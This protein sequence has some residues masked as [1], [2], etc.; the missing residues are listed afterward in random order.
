MGIQDKELQKLSQEIS[1]KIS[2]FFSGN[3]FTLF[4]RYCKMNGIVYLDELSNFNF[5]V[6]LDESSFGVTKIKKIKERYKKIDSLC[7]K[8][9]GNKNKKVYE[10]TFYDF[11]LLTNISKTESD[12]E[13]SEPFNSFLISELGYSVRATNI[14]NEVKLTSIGKLLL[15]TTDKLLGKKNCGKTTIIEI[16][17]KCK[18]FLDKLDIENIETEIEKIIPVE[19]S[20]KEEFSI[21]NL[22]QLPIFSANAIESNKQDLHNS[23]FGNYKL[24]HIPFDVRTT[25]TMHRLKL[26]SL[27]ELLFFP[28]SSIKLVTGSGKKTIENIHKTLT[29]FY[30]VI[31][32]KNKQFESFQEMLTEILS[33][34]PE[35]LQIFFDRL[36][37]FDKD[38]TLESVGRKYNLTR[39][40]V[41]QIIEKIENLLLYPFIDM[42]LEEFY[43]GIDLVLDQYIGAVNAQMINV[44]LSE[45][46]DWKENVSPEMLLN[47]CLLNNRYRINKQNYLLFSKSENCNECNN[48]FEFM[49]SYFLKESSV[50][51]IV[52]CEILYKICQKSCPSFSKSKKIDTHYINW[53]ITENEELNKFCVY[54]DEEKIYYSKSAWEEKNRSNYNHILKLL[55]SI[56]DSIH[57]S[58][59]VK[60]VNSEL[61]FNY[62]QNNLSSLLSRSNS[63]YLWDRGTILAKSN[64]EFPH[65]FIESKIEELVFLLDEKK[66]PVIY[67]NGYFKKINQECKKYKIPN[68]TAL[69]SILRDANE[70]KLT[71]IKYPSIFLSST[72][73]GKK[74]IT[75]EILLLLGEN[76]NRYNY[77]NLREYFVNTLGAASYVFQNAVANCTQLEKSG[78]TISIVN[79]QSNIYAEE[80]RKVKNQLQIP[81][82]IINYQDMF[83]K[84]NVQL[85][86][87]IKYLLYQLQ[88]K[89][90]SISSIRL[91]SLSRIKKINFN[92]IIFN[93]NSQFRSIYNN[94][95]LI[96]E[97]EIW[98]VNPFFNHSANWGHKDKTTDKEMTDIELE[99]DSEEEYPKWLLKQAVKLEDIFKHS[100]TSY[101]YYWFQA[102]L[103]LVERGKKE[104]SFKQMAAI[105]CAHAWKDVLIKNCK[106][107]KIDQIPNV[108]RRIYLDSHL[109]PAEN[110]NPIIDYLLD[111]LEKYDDLFSQLIAMVPYRFLSNFNEKL[112]GLKDYQKN[113]FIESASKEYSFMYKI[114]SPKIYID[115]YWIKFILSNLVE[116]KKLI[117]KIQICEEK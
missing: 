60:V 103:T 16:V 41:R 28:S 12:R 104:A 5:N 24:S 20:L 91:H 61:N 17:N 31:F 80:L 62:S 10:K 37:S 72:F 47:F 49:K 50:T 6:L 9:S 46:L 85:T 43:D 52:F 111:N 87:T 95:F 55:E 2:D 42:Q 51:E 64:F 23:Y 71:L 92:T 89:G 45:L 109:Q 39:E 74:N 68:P 8:N 86:E 15:V 22:L 40:R 63:I 14:I 57:M 100:I 3:S 26:V 98:E 77:T 78:N 66:Y 115:N 59:L 94:N 58:E 69:Y 117:K 27:K 30:K 79:K 112:T 116:L 38:A 107:A 96:F 101:K 73:K 84:N 97:N 32:S 4:R 102:I 44:D 67:V 75:E 25:N 88:K 33:T 21:Q 105:M 106:Y 34:K 11:P 108:V 83:I 81:S 110:E 1:T 29:H 7:T 70:P 18:D 54:D 53:I 114:D 82:L 48:L 36:S 13:A 113:N 99:K 35:K 76:N 19:Q 93:L 56:K 65:D 90:G